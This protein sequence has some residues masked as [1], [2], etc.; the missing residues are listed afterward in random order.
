MI[1]HFIL[2]FSFPFN[3]FVA[4]VLMHLFFLTILLIGMIN[5]NNLEDRIDVDWYDLLLPVLAFAYVFEDIVA[6]YQ[7][8]G[9]NTGW[10]QYYDLIF[11]LSVLLGI[12]LRAIGFYGACIGESEHT[13]LFAVLY[14]CDKENPSN[15]TDFNKV[16]SPVVYGYVFYAFG[17]L[18]GS[19]KLLYWTQLSHTLGPL[20]ISIKSVFKDIL[21]VAF[22]YF[23]FLISF[24]MAMKYVMELAESDGCGAGDAK[25]QD[26]TICPFDLDKEVNR[27][28]T[29]RDAIKTFFWSLFDPGHPEVV[30]CA[31]GFP[32]Y[33]GLIMWGSYQCINVMILM[34]LLIA[35]MNSTFNSIRSEK[36]N[37]WKFA[38]TEIWLSY[39]NKPQYVPAPFNLIEY[40]IHSFKR[41]F[42]WGKTTIEQNIE[43]EESQDRYKDLVM[44]LCRRF[45]NDAEDSKE[46]EV[47][48]EDLDNFKRDIY[49][50][51]QNK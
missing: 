26:V 30:G 35:M 27:F 28:L 2:F 45:L 23:M 34:N 25:I 50:I 40:P 48:K 1:H 19:L 24:S 21:L 37:E 38:R 11:H 49:K 41:L 17:M 46:N 4:D 20:V 7:F 10:L 32:R 43:L 16:L 31:T 14:D 15:S 13:N 47:T 22:T 39:L 3:R 51:F 8:R 29:Y 44:E 5:P 42:G 9:I 33:A 12:L 18:M 6:V 36:I